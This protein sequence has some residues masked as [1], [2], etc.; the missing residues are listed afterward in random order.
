VGRHGRL[1]QLS[2]QIPL[3]KSPEK[4]L[5]ELPSNGD[6]E[7]VSFP[8]NRRFSGIPPSLRPLNALTG[9][10]SAKSVC[11]ILTSKS[12]E[13][14]ILTTRELDPLSRC[15]SIPLPPRLSSACF[16][17]GARLDVTCDLWISR[18]TST[19]RK[20]GEKWARIIRGC[21]ALI[22]LRPAWNRLEP[23]AVR[24]PRE[25]RQAGNL[26]RLRLSCRTGWCGRRVPWL[27]EDFQSFAGSAVGHHSPGHYGRPREL[28]F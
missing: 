25:P 5:W 2:R 6:L 23:L 1:P 9:A 17:R 20:R 10:G 7:A 22:R 26:L 27:S 12:L 19:S 24:T 15:L 16:A 11:K 18:S 8:E 13:V 3:W 14:K 4:I 21:L 28:S